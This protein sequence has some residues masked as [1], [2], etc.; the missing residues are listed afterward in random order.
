[1]SVENVPAV[2]NIKTLKGRFIAHKFSTG[3]SVGVVKSVDY[4]VDKNWVLLAVVNAW[5]AKAGGL[6]PCGGDLHTRATPP[7][8]FTI[9][10]THF[11]F[12]TPA[13]GREKKYCE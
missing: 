7:S 11:S 12:S 8:G 6:A 3:W 9:F 2:V 10:N 4:G 1:M 5:S 13:K